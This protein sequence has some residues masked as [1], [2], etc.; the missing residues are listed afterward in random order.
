M[1]PATIEIRGPRLAQVTR[2][3][4]RHDDIQ[5]ELR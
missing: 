1:D 2:K 3:Y 4:R 5:H